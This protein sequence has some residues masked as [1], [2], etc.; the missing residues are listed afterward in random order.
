MK[1]LD[2]ATLPSCS[3]LLFKKLKRSSYIARLWGNWLNGNLRDQDV[4]SFGWRMK[5][6]HYNI[7]W[8]DG[9][10]ALKIVDVVHQCEGALLEI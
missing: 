3:R 5:N 6:G 10:A 1:K 4:L 2:S 7:Q 8:L 9:D